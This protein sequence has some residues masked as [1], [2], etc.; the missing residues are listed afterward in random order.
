[1]EL[2]SPLAR[3]VLLLLPLVV[4]LLPLVVPLLLLVVPLPQVRARS[5]L[6]TFLLHV[7]YSAWT[8]GVL[9]RAGLFS[10]MQLFFGLE[11]ARRIEFLVGFSLFGG[12]QRKLVLLG[13]FEPW[14]VGC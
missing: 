1:M 7:V 6:R 3:I 4:P 9:V 11:W 10:W 2:A 12:F 13:F 5:C 8:R 14:F